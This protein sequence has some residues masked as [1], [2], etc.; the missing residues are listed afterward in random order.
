MK[1]L[2][3]RIKKGKVSW[4]PSQLEKIQKHPC[5]SRK[6][7]HLEKIKEIFDLDITTITVTI[8]ALDSTIEEKKL[9]D[10]CSKYTRQMKHYRQC[11]ANTIGK[12]G[13]AFYG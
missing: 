4:D 3:A 7:F 1:Y 9:Q 10:E 8:N 11:R 13:E 12:L 5:Y 2:F 6:V